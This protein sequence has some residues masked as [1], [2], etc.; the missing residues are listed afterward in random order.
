[1]KTRK[2]FITMLII[3]V[4][5]MLFAGCTNN[6]RNSS[7]TGATN[8]IKYENYDFWEK[9]NQLLLTINVQKKEAA[10]PFSENF[11]QMEF[12]ELPEKNWKTVEKIRKGM[13]EFFNE[14]YSIDISEKISQQEIKVFIPVIDDG[15]MGFV[16][17]EE[18]NVMYVNQEVLDEYS[19]FFETTYIHETI[20]QMGFMGKQRTILDEGFTDA[21]TDMICCYI[22]EKP[23][24]TP[25]YTYPRLVAYQMLKADPKIVSGYLEND[26]F[27]IVKRI[28][29]RLKDVPQTGEQV[30]NIGQNLEVLLTFFVNSQVQ[31]PFEVN[32]HPMAMIRD[33][34]EI[35]RAYCQECSPDHETID[36]IR[37][38]YCLVEYEEIIVG[39]DPVEGYYLELI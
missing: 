26:D 27:D 14:K 31:N 9:E 38:H 1:M 16:R 3:V 23:V 15:T 22:G 4:I 25:L 39:D 5:C 28:N 37:N 7:D 6:W 10:D 32:V 2:H 35:T 30:Y 18:P 29:H 21:I 12:F 13:I 36:Y 17:P 20:H 11:D 33:V 34:Q 8:I 19:E 24:L